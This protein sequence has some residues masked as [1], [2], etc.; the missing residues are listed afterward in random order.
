MEDIGT[1]A[2][3][4]IDGT[5]EAQVLLE[6]A[7]PA[8]PLRVLVTET[9]ARGAP[10]VSSEGLQRRLFEVYDVASTVPEALALVQ[11]NLGLTLDRTWYSAA[12]VHALADQIDALLAAGPA[13]QV[14]PEPAGQAPGNGS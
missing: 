14:D 12:E 1:A 3:G 7:A 13:V 6:L 5:D 9:E 8:E 11:R 2:T 10:M 4:T